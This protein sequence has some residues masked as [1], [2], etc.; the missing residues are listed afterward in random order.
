MEVA[1]TLPSSFGVPMAVTWSPT[2]KSETAP[3]VV[4]ITS[5]ES[6]K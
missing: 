4:F 3:L 2:A 6:E 1:V 5:V